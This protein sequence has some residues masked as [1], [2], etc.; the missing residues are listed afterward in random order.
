MQTVSEKSLFVSDTLILP[1]ELAHQCVDFFLVKEKRKKIKYWR[2][3]AS[4]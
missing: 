1:C 3:K 2:N 4:Y